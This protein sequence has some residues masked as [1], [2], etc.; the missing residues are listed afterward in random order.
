MRASFCAGCAPERMYACVPLFDHRSPTCMCV[1][2]SEHTCTS[3][4]RG[5]RLIRKGWRVWESM[6]ERERAWEG[7]LVEATNRKS[8]G[9]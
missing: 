5:A 2:I 1:H 4:L 6:R 3:R 8:Y 7:G 9:E